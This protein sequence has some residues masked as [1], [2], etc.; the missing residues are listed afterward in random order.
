EL[1]QVVRDS[2]TAVV[3]GTPAVLEA[4]DVPH[5]FTAPPEESGAPV[6]PPTGGDDLAVLIYTS[7][8]EG[9]PK[10]AMLS[11]RALLA[12]HEQVAAVEPQPISGDDVL[13]LAVPLVHA[14][15]LNS[16]LG[17]VAWQREPGG[18]TARSAARTHE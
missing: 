1:N 5:R 17:A 12:N 13:L 11:H 10:G 3:I 6:D 14:Y 15:G 4:V 7:G 9:D 16:G 2:A 8:T 18:Q